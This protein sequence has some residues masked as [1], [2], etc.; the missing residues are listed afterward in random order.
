[1]LRFNDSRIA[2]TLLATIACALAAR[3]QSPAAAAPAESREVFH[4]EHI[5]G[6]S[7]RIEVR[8]GKAESAAAEKKVLAE[9]ERLRMILSDYDNSSEIVKLKKATA[10]AP[11]SVELREVLAAAAKWMDTTKGVFNPGIGLLVNLWRDAAKRGKAPSDDELKAAIAKLKMELWTVDDKAGTAKWNTDL[12]ITLDAIAKG[13]IVERAALAATEGAGDGLFVEIG[14]DLRTTGETTFVVSVANPQTPADNT[15]PICK[16]YVRNAALATSGGYARGF[17][18]NG[19]HYSHILDPRTG[20]PVEN[21]LQ[22]TVI[23]RDAVTADAVATI[24]NILPPKEGVELVDSLD[25]AACLIIDKDGKLYPSRDWKH[26]LDP[27]YE[28]VAPVASAWPG[29][30][31]VKIQ[32]DIAQPKQNNNSEG[33]GREGGPREGGPREGGGREGRGKKGGYRRPY[34]AVWAENAEGKAVRTLTLWV[35]KPKWIPDLTHWSKLYNN[36][37]GDVEAVTRATRAPGHYEMSWDG[38][39]DAGNAVPFGKYTIYVEAVRE[40]GT[41]QIMKQDVSIDGKPF[42]FTMPGGV[43]LASGKVMF[44]KPEKKP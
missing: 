37:R 13:Y 12:P 41:Y 1:M 40:H 39:D 10:P 28:M 7:L 6:T 20:R 2:P 44:T 43:E 16:V 25:R 32:F 23:A 11:A 9:I 29:G 35:Q 27:S 18:I 30:G 19:K 21:V 4:H 34:V 3:A 42:S 38:R 14:G 15:K 36:R 33:G 17:D 24:L 5:L 31:E 8:A 26:Y 22:A